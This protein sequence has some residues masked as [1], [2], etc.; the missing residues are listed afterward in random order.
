M[1]AGLPCTEHPDQSGHWLVLDGYESS[2]DV[3]LKDGVVTGANFRFATQD[4]EAV[5]QKVADVFKSFG[6]SV[7]DDEGLL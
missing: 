6:W 2:L 5:I 3:T 7:S 1:E 4:D